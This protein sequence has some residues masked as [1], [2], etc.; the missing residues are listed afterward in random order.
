MSGE[1]SRELAAS[2]AKLRRGCKLIKR[3]CIV[4]LI[5]FT[6]SWAV[7]LALTLFD[8]VAVGVD[9]EKVRTVL[10]I[11]CNG[12]IISFL[13]VI[14]VQIFAG[15]VAGDSPFTMKQVRR[16]RVTALL[17]FALAFVEALLAA[18]FSQ[19]VNVP[20]TY[21]V[22]DSVGG[23]EPVPIDINIMILFFAV[24]I[25]GVSIVFQYGNLLQ[26]LSDET[27]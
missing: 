26:R 22:Y 21:V 4:C 13:L 1:E 18:N 3:F 6:A 15:I 19:V 7:L 5:G 14:S 10:Y 24:M 20:N 25:L 27:E 12:I 23:A 16:F 2:I 17:L 8:L 11:L 9:G